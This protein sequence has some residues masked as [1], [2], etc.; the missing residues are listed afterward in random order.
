[1]TELLDLAALRLKEADGLAKRKSWNKS[2]SRGKNRSN[3]QPASK[4]EALQTLE[5][6]QNDYECIKEA[7]DEMCLGYERIQKVVA[8]PKPFSSC[9]R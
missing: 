9:L 7:A 1:M 4:E 5:Q 6:M 8:V 2:Q 3:K